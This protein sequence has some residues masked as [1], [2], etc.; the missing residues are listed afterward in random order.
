MI[1]EVKKAEGNTGA[2]AGSNSS[3]GLYGP[4]LSSALR[5]EF[6]KNKIKNVFVSVLT[7]TGG[8]HIYVKFRMTEAD[9]VPYDEY[10]TKKM[11]V[12]DFF[13][14]NCSVFSYKGKHY[15]MDDCQS[16]PE[17]E[18]M[19]LYK[20]CLKEHYGYLSNLDKHGTT[21]NQYHVKK[22]ADVFSEGF[23]NKLAFVKKIVDSFNYDNSNSMVDYFDRGFCESYVVY[24]P[25]SFMLAV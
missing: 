13:Q 9:Y 6:K 15:N 24:K 14:F 25:Q 23:L 8:Q 2:W 22:Y 16:L 5:A 17:E 12:V 18:R 3:R 10:L 7:Y 19:A 1:Y 4:K 11:K 20:K 21:I